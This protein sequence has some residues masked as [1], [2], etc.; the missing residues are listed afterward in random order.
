MA[1][2]TR[3]GQNKKMSAELKSALGS[4]NKKKEDFDGARE[5]AK[6]VNPNWGKNGKQYT[7]NCQRCVIGFEEQMRGYDVE[8]LAYQ[9]K[10]DIMFE[11]GRWMRMYE[12]QSWEI[13]LGNRNKKV[14]ENVKKQMEA[15]GEGARAICYVAWKGGDAHVF[16]LVQTKAGLLGVDAQSGRAN[17]TLWEAY[18]NDAKPSM[19]MI[20]RVDGLREKDDI[21]LAVK[22]KGKK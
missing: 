3:G 6:A 15:W 12:G 21:K 16:N 7:H 9:G 11:N 1:K 13:N 18:L 5:A 10:G 2:P 22:K 14:I 20:S 19:T 8:A 4:R 17:Y